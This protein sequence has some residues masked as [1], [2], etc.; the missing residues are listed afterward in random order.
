MNAATYG[1]WQKYQNQNPLQKRLIGRFLAEVNS[2]LAPLPIHTVLD[3]GCAEGFVLD[4]LKQAR[5]ELAV[6]GLDLDAAA[7]GR[8]RQLFPGIPLA[9]ASIFHVPCPPAAFDLVLCTEVLEHLADPA[10]GLRELRRV[11]R[12][13]CLLSVPH[14]PFFRLGSLLRGKNLPRL[15][16]DPEHLQNWSQASFVRFLAPHVNVVAVRRSFPWL[17]ALAEVG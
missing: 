5:P 4:A 8:G 2:M 7:L 9:Q 17:I 16:N 15:G 13:Y 6:A 12:R 14:E 10:V 3:V 11:S 1:N